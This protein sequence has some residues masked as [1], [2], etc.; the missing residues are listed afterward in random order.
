M[1]FAAIFFLYNGKITFFH[2]LG[3]WIKVH[4][5]LNNESINLTFGEQYT[6]DKSF[7]ETDIFLNNTS[8]GVDIQYCLLQGKLEK[9]FLSFEVLTIWVWLNCSK[10]KKLTPLHTFRVLMDA[11]CSLISVFWRWSTCRSLLNYGERG[12]VSA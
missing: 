7:S 6:C 3:C 2:K 10:A 4:F 5:Y 12:W 8:E 9:K 1:V 11:N